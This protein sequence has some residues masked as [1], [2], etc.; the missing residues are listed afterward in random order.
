[1]DKWIDKEKFE[2]FKFNLTKRIKAKANKPHV[3]IRTLSDNLELKSYNARV[4]FIDPNGANRNVTLLPTQQYKIDLYFIIY[5]TASGAYDL[6]VKDYTAT[7]IITIGQD[8]VAMI[9]YFKEPHPSTVGEWRAF[10]SG[11]T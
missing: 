5:N 4:Q 3:E 1:M 8:E 7:E 6:I 11:K 9:F 10:K 2:T